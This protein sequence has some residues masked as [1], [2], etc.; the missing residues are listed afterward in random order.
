MTFVAEFSLPASEFSVGAVLEKHSNIRL[1]LE[2]IVPTHR[3]LFPFVFVWS[4]GAFDSI[5]ADIRDDPAVTGLEEIEQVEGG[6]LYRVRWDGSTD[7]LGEAIRESEATL[8]EAVGTGDSW[9]FEIRFR[10]QERIERFQELVAEF[11]LEL[12]LE[13]LHTQLEISPSMEYDLTEKQVAALA[14]AFESGFFEN[15][16]ETTLE[17][18]GEELG[19]SDAAVAG[20]INRGLD[21]L[22]S[23]TVMRHEDESA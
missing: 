9:T 20:R 19:L 2:S 5:E 18:V 14:T 15:P 4:D 6:R 16:K 23:E 12:V 3:G 21:R 10:E 22:L 8:L 7:G 1:E 13:R 17:E 11:D